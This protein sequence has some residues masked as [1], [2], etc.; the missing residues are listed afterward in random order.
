MDRAIRRL[1]ITG[2]YHAR[3]PGRVD[4]DMS[5]RRMSFEP[6]CGAAVAHGEHEKRTGA[7]RDENWPDWYAEYMVAEQSA[8][9]L[10]L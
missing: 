5:T 9:P 6:R 3:S 2:D 4:A 7:L 8:K 1:A 10:P